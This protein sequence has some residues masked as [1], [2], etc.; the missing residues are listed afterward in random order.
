MGKNLSFSGKEN[1]G[2]VSKLDPQAESDAISN[3]LH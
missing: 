1:M 2:K 3:T